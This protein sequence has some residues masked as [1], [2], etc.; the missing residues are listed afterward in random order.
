MT[1]IQLIPTASID[2]AALPRDRSALD[3]RA[4]EE[5]RASIA[6]NGLRLPIE[7]FPTETG[8]GLLSGYRR[9]MAM[10]ALEEMYGERFATIAAFIR[11]A[12]DIAAAFVRV[13]EEN[14]IRENLSP[15]ERGRT[16]VVA[17]DAGY[18]TL[19]A[20]LAALYP[21]AD[22]RKQGRLRMLAEV[23]EALEDDIDLPETWSENRLL[24]IGQA[25]RLGWDEL[26]LAALATA[27][28]GEEWAA[29]EPLITECESLPPDQRKTPGRPRRLVHIP[30]GLTIR[31]ERTRHGFVLHISGRRATDSLVADMLEEIERW[32]A[33]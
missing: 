1:D 9:L 14:D 7:V 33:A 4:L 5:L 25:L 18:E 8:Y 29:I 20:A 24:R 31:R 22:R 10:R 13:V 15:W 16:L 32:F 3:T 28:P 30:W 6:A 2:E 19:D 26:I 23:V 17:R 11:P 12:E 27:S 21:H